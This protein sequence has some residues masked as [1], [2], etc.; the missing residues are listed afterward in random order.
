MESLESRQLLA[1]DVQVGFKEIFIEGTLSDD[2][3]EVMYDARQGVGVRTTT[4]GQSSYIS[5]RLGEL[6]RINFKGSAGNDQFDN[7]TDLELVAYG[8]PDNDIINCGNSRKSFVR[9]ETGRDILIGNEFRNE[10]YGD[11][12]N[13][14][15]MGLG[16]DDVLFGGTDDDTLLGYGGNDILFGGQGKDKLD[17]GKGVDYMD[18]GADRTID[19]ITN[20]L[21]SAGDVFIGE[22]GVTTIIT[23]AEWPLDRYFEFDYDTEAEFRQ[24]GTLPVSMGVRSSGYQLGPGQSFEYLAQDFGFSANEIDIAEQLIPVDGIGELFE[25]P[26]LTHFVDDVSFEEEGLLPSAD[27]GE[28]LDIDEALIDDSAIDGIFSVDYA[29]ESPLPPIIPTTSWIEPLTAF[30]SP[31]LSSAMYSLSF[32]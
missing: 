12:E 18:P 1:V 4:N 2:I 24:K 8:G 29:E 3:V 17:G 26:S 21:D 30:S 31:R 23:D 6:Q 22:K 25:D 27:D 28:L 15:L 32:R 9:G 19:T 7:S 13:D 14:V 16:G 10:M 20:N 5:F 11:E